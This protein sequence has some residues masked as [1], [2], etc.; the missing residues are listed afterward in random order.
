MPQPLQ[1]G[2]VTFADGTS[3]AL[4]AEAHDV[5]TFLAWAAEPTMEARKET[6]AKV[7]LFLFVMA[8][9]LYGA[10]RKIWASLHAEHV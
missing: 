10:K 2:S 7:M 3:S 8:G 5:C 1:D 4:P 9:L 6:G